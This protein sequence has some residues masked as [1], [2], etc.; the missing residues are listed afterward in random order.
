VSRSGGNLPP[1]AGAP[2][3]PRLGAALRLIGSHDAAFRR[4]AGRHSLCADDAED[5]YQRA[6]EILLTKAPD[7]EPARLAAW[8][9][10]VTKHEALAVRRARERLLGVRVRRLGSEGEAGHP[11]SLASESAGPAERAE[12][13]EHVAR[14]SEALGLLKPHERR[15]LALKAEGYSYAEIGDLTGW[16]FTKINRCMA[17]GRKSFLELFARIE[18]GRRCEE[19]AAALASLR[20]EGPGADPGGEL[21]RH[22]RA[23]ARCRAAARLRTAAGAAP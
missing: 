6:L 22:L 5:A 7:C 17:E 14:S 9:H 3:S 4:T 10:T 19:L 20:A 8:M 11:D 16:T 12:R 23:C 1:S 21:R 2:G 15:A 18:S 13:R